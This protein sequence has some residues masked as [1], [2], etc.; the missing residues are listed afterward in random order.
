MEMG[1]VPSSQ[2]EQ[3]FVEIYFP[4]HNSHNKLKKKKEG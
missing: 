1:R 4:W 3:N 2:P